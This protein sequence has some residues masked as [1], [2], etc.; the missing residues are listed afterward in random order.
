VQLHFKYTNFKINKGLLSSEENMFELLVFISIILIFHCYFG[1]PVS[2]KVIGLFRK[3]KTDKQTIFPKTT[4]IISAHNEAV[5]IEDKIRNTLQ[6]KYPEDK[7][8]IIVASDGSTDQTN[9]IVRKYE[10]EGVILIDI[11]NRNGKENA[12]K[13]AIKH[14]SGEIL[15]FTD[16]ATLLEPNGLTEI[17][18][19]FSDN[20]VGCVSSVDRL[21]GANGKGSGEGFYLRYEMWLRKLESQVNSL[22]GLSGSFFAARK[23]VCHDFAS[24]MPSD[25]RTV[26]NSVRK[27]LRA[28]SD[29]DSIGYYHNISNENKEFQR[30]VRTV[31]RGFA[32]FFEHIGLLNVFKYGLF[33]YQLFCHKLLRWLVPGFLFVAFFS[34]VFL[35]AE[36]VWYLFLFLS[37][38]GFYGLAA[39]GLIQNGDLKSPPIKIPTYFIT[40]NAAIVIAWWRFLRGQRI[41][42]W[43]PSER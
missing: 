20:R 40:V 2:L 22:V 10:K 5:H 31:L 30:K 43:T 4:L 7:L 3:R 34:S 17:V 12:Q 35:A 13:E 37:Q 9:E 29:S 24:D 15:V 27:G 42:A 26:F 41:T 6:L 39:W 8:Q 1:Y 11:G 33:S 32:V 18:A 14:S 28:I 21:V 19:N 23:Q 36:S 16:V 38:L 25:F